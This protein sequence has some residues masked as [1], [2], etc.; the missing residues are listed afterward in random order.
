MPI[1]ALLLC[2]VA[3]VFFAASYVLQYHEAHQAP[4]RLFLSPKLLLALARHPIWLAGIAAMVIGNLLQAAA[5]GFGSLAVV[6]PVLTTSLL[7]ALPMSAAWRRERLARRDWFGAIL[8]SGGIAVLLAVGQPTAGRSTMPAIQ[9]TFTCLSTWGVASLLVAVG[10]R[11]AGPARASL[12][13]GAAGV[14]FG[15]QDALTRDALALAGSHGVVA[16]LASWQP[17]VLLVSAIYGLTL[18]QSSYEAGTLPAALPAMTVGEPVV[19]MLIG[20]VAL[21]EVVKSNAPYL[22]GEV[23]G[24][25]I[26]IYG[27]YELAR[28]PLVL[29]RAHLTHRPRPVLDDPAPAGSP[30]AG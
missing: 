5:L 27:T 12:I 19:G 2:L 28:S 8:V 4:E 17:Y 25:L 23:L 18:A 10:Q 9:W 11:L 1:L 20:T 16:L 3:S 22:L 21:G 26:M 15:L 30:P 13:G 6:E 29:G 14:L 7:F 24:G